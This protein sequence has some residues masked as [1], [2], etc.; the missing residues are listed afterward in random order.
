ME[1]LLIPLLAKGTVF[2]V[3]SEENFICSMMADV[4]DVLENQEKA[5]ITSTLRAFEIIKAVNSH[6]ELDNRLK[7]IAEIIEKVDDRCLAA[8]GAVT[9]TLDE[10]SQDEIKEIYNFAKGR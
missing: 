5:I 7:G 9:E 10:I 2:I 1:H 6:D 3:D 4:E 8:D